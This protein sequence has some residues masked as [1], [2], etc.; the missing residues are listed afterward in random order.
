MKTA[1][2]AALLSLASLAAAQQPTKDAG[3]DACLEKEI[4]DFTRNI[5][6]DGDRL[7]IGFL[8]EH[9]TWSDDYRRAASDVIQSRFPT[10]FVDAGDHA[11]GLIVLY[12]HGTD[13]VSSGAQ[14]V[15]VRLQ[16]NSSEI[17]LPENVKNFLDFYVA[18]IG[19]PT[20]VMSGELVFAE[21]GILLPPIGQMQFELWHQLSIQ[22]VRK[23]VE[24]VLSDFAAKWEQTRKK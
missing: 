3:K 6:A 17:L 5:E 11:L 8:I 23:T 20:R 18:K 2:F 21:E 22:E 24:K 1:Y 15:D 12:I 4:S 19:D 10:K 13:A 16:L 9:I 14:F 7:K